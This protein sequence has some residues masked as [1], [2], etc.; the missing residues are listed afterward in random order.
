MQIFVYCGDYIV[1]SR[2]AFLN[3]LE[4]FK[5]DGHEVIKVAGKELS[6]ESLEMLSTPV[7]LFGEKRALVVEGLLSGQKSKEKETII[8]VVSLLE[9]SVIL[10]ENKSFS[11]NDQLKYPKNFVF[12]NFKLPQVIFNFLDSLEPGKT[13]ANLKYLY[14]V[15]ESVDTTYFFFDAVA[16]N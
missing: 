7:S 13:G 5:K 6:P 9:C 15:L 1:S 4:G 12:K 3:N 2:K 10:W 8:K 14:R 16:A 11:K